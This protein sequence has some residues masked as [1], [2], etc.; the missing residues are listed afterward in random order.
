M[1]IVS[2][3]VV[4]ILAPF[5]S[6]L[7]DGLEKVA[8]KLGFSK[9]E[10]QYPISFLFPDYEAV[11]VNSPYLKVVLPGLFGVA[12][13]FAFTTGLYLIISRVKI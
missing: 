13:T 4:L 12:V 11:F 7:P 9:F 10:K 8:E 1:F 6:P 5:A 3:L 2:L